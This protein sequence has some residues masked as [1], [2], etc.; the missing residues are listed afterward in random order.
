MTVISAYIGPRPIH[1]GDMEI[2]A[3]FLSYR[4]NGVYDYIKSEWS[5]L[6]VLKTTA[7]LIVFLRPFGIEAR[8]TDIARQDIYLAPLSNDQ[9][10]WQL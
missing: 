1:P 10:R 3:E 2:N 5:V 9:A 4:L 6:K 7:V 8:W